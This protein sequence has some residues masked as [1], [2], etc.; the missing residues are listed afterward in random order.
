VTL[1]VIGVTGFLGI[2]SSSD[3]ELESMTQICVQHQDLALALF[4]LVMSL[5]GTV[6]KLQE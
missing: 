4:S 1:P 2:L 3:S 6:Y 5:F